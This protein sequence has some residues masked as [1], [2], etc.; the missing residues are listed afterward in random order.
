MTTNYRIEL[1]FQYISSVY[2]VTNWPLS[3]SIVKVLQ[4]KCCYSSHLEAQLT[5]VMAP[6]GDSPNTC[7][8]TSHEYIRL[9]ISS[10]AQ[11]TLQSCH[12]K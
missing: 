12:E 4:L 2:T 5:V 9:G 10:P 8:G 11:Y 6:L 1:L 7:Y 3:S